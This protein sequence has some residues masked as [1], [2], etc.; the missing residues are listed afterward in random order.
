MPAINGAQ[1][2]PTS[3]QLLFASV[4]ILLLG[5]FARLHNLG[6]DSFW[7]DEILTVKTALGGPSAFLEVRDHPP[8]MYALT[9][10]AIRALGETEFSVRMPALVAGMLALPLTILLG[11]LLRQRVA[12]LW[13]ALLLAVSLVH[14]RS[15]QEARHYALLLTISLATFILLYRAVK[16]PR[17]SLWIAFALLTAL[18]LYNHYGALIVLISQALL[19]LGWLV[20]RMRSKG[21]SGSWQY[22]RYP[23]ASGFLALLLYLPWLPHLRT[24]TKRNLGSD[25]VTGTGGT[26]SLAEWLR[27]LF[28]RFGMYH[29]WIPYL[30]LLLAL[31]GITVLVWRRRWPIL[32]LMASAIVLPLLLIQLFQVSRGAFAR[33]VLYMLPFYLLAAGR[34]QSALIEKAVGKKFG[35]RAHVSASVLL[36]AL[37][38]LVAWPG[39]VADYDRIQEDWRG[40]LRYLEETAADGD[41]LVGASMNFRN[42]FNLVASSLP[43]YLDL[44]E[45]DYVWLPAG[46]F[47][48]DQASELASYQGAAWLVAF[49]WNQPSILLDS[50][51]DVKPFQTA[52]FVGREPVESGNSLDNTIALFS[53]LIGVTKDPAQ[54]C[55]LMEDR[56]VLLTAKGKSD[57]ALAELDMVEADCPDLVDRSRFIDARIRALQDQLDVTLAAGRLPEAE[58][59]AV[60][61][62][63]YLPDNVQALDA[64]T[65]IDLLQLLD[66]SKAVIDELDSP[67]PVRVM[68]FTMPREGDPR[69]VI[70]VH[71]PASVTY[72]LTLPEGHPVLHTRLALAPESWYWGGDGVTFMVYLR[73]AGGAQ[74]ELLR[75][76]IANDEPSHVWHIVDIPLH[77]YAGQEVFLT[78]ATQAGPAGDATGDW[79]GW[80]TPRI[81]RK[82]PQSWL[83]G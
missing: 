35:L 18:N 36:A 66:S 11:K 51:L 41:V 21:I 25:I 57:L 60:R 32:V 74:V 1:I 45:D 13:A 17:W 29:G 50:D 49:D 24:V 4:S 44:T 82:F 20:S 65:E 27:V 78:F 46:Q 59:I 76:H 48:L 38:T 67:E 73:S 63:E 19:I 9:S 83:P 72:R 64:V 3:R 28:N 31:I 7:F 12:G 81:L 80:E 61:L 52:L 23:A 55:M 5:F 2:N 8:L 39:I 54:T 75:R 79:A 14:I 34:G 69:D 53:E 47:D 22:W 10:M 70:L 62:L 40:I 58:Q 15:S 6:G 77:E 37:I 16:R 26:T 42:Q 33:Y 71:P 43:Y 68:Q 30:L 56:A